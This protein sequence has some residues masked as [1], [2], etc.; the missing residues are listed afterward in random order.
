MER[1]RVS[2]CTTGSSVV[3]WGQERQPQ[4]FRL[5]FAA[6]NMTDE[7]IEEDEWLEDGEWSTAHP[8]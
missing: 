5:R 7:W 4:M 1:F 6:L 8:S 2:Y 3:R